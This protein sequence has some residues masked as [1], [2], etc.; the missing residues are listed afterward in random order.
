MQELIRANR[1]RLER[2]L[3]NSTKRWFFSPAAYSQYRVTLPLVQRFARGRLI[4]L[5][6]GDVPF[7]PFIIDQLDTY[8]SLDL[9]PRTAQVTYVGDVQTLTM[10]ADNAYDTVLCLEVLEH[11]PDPFRAAREIQRILKPNG[12]V[13]LSVPHLSRLHDEPNDYYRYTRYGIEHLLEQAGLEA[14]IVERRGGLFSFVGH[15][16]S[17]LILGLIWGIPVI[18]DVVWFLNSWLV[19]RLCT[20]L[21]QLLDRT[22][23]FALGYTVVA[24]VQPSVRAKRV[25]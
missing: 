11:V 10:C 9:Y 5:G 24:R 3:L 25:A 18:K 17:T 7:R 23:I 12:C 1:H 15:Q 2:D 14:E 6:C 22:G 16:V 8:E 13:I 20:Y 4:D 19:T 21:D